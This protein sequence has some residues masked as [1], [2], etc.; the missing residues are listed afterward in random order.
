MRKFRALCLALATVVALFVLAASAS[1]AV[2]LGPPGFTAD[3]A[4][5][6]VKGEETVQN[7]FI[8]TGLETFCKNV[9]LSG[10]TSEKVQAS[11]TITPSYKECEGESI[12]GTVEVTMTGFGAGECDY[13][14][15]A[16]GTADLECAAGKEVTVDAVTCT[17]HVPGQKGIGTLKF[18][19]EEKAGVKD[20]RAHL[21]LTSITTNH[22]D[23]FGCPLTSG[24]ESATGTF[25]GTT[26]FVGEAGGKSV[27]ISWDE[28]VS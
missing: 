21:E 10:T 3:N 12:F 9:S 17:I 4:D 28:H 6:T 18:T 2:E 23:G 1:A 15:N 22:T 11:M 8:V 16:T 19:N 7:R 26:T 25:T 27:G 5:T 24:G 14:V 13:R 20:I